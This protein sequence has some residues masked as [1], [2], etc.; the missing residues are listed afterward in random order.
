MVTRAAFLERTRLLLAV[1]AFAMGL[2]GVA[3][4][5]AGILSVATVAGLGDWCAA[6]GQGAVAADDAA[7]PSDHPGQGHD[8]AQCPLCGWSTTPFAPSPAAPSAAL[9][10]VRAEQ[11]WHADVSSVEGGQSIAHT[12]DP[13]ALP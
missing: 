9:T 11:P 4:A 12:R 2:A 10:A 8:H 1:L 3:P 5:M 7:A 13:P 6:A